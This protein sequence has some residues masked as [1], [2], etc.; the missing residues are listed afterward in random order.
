MLSSSA[1]PRSPLEW[2]IDRIV[3]RG[4]LIFGDWLD[5]VLS[6][7]MRLTAAFVAMMIRTPLIV[8]ALVV[9]SLV[10]LRHGLLRALGCVVAVYLIWSLDLADQSLRT[11]GLAFVGA[12]VGL[13]I[14]LPAT[15][16]GS[17]R[18]RLVGLRRPHMIILA[19]G[20]LGIVV[21]PL[22][23]PTRVD[24]PWIVAI[25]LAASLSGTWGLR[26]ELQELGTPALDR[27]RFLAGFYW[28]FYGSVVIALLLGA[29]GMEGLG[30]ELVRSLQSARPGWAVASTI[31]V[32]LFLFVV[33][34]I[35]TAPHGLGAK[36]S[37]PKTA[38]LEPAD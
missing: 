15:L 19:V 37:L 26:L 33:F 35:M 9:G 25:A 10:Y 13:V 30:A 17:W 22:V 38:R 1:V 27:R 5:P 16:I 7:A 8:A 6:V 4:V 23:V 21:V 31:G 29:A 11:F 28:A 24:T 32:L 34:S 2:L 3:E 14:A 36:D 18:S 12:V 20:L